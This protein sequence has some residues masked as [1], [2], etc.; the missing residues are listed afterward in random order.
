MPGS[1]QRPP[2]LPWA[3]TPCPEPR[4]SLL[5]KGLPHTPPCYH[6][7]RLT[8]GGGADRESAENML[9]RDGSFQKSLP[10]CRLGSGAL[11][12]LPCSALGQG[13]TPFTH[14]FIHSASWAPAGCEV[15]FQLS[16]DTA[17]NKRDKI[18]A[19]LSTGD[20]Q[21]KEV[22]ERPRATVRR[23]RVGCAQLDGRHPEDACVLIPGTCAC[24]PMWPRECSLS[25]RLRVTMS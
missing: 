11:S 3:E 21:Q 14:S 2:C 1:Q 7:P 15:L 17:L 25:M 9:C 22:K 16:R 24:H 12:P 23:K 18:P 5:Q 13:F 4:F 19:F 10:W 8:G 6:L 20:N